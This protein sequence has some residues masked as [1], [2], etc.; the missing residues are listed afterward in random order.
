MW[1]MFYRENANNVYQNL[2]GEW[3]VNEICLNQS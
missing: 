1:I 3:I 2:N